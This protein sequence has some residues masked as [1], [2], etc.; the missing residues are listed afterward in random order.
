[1]FRRGIGGGT[2]LAFVADTLVVPKTREELLLH[3]AHGSNKVERSNRKI[4][5]VDQRDDPPNRFRKLFHQIEIA[6]WGTIYS[7]KDKKQIPDSGSRKK[8]SNILE[9]ISKMR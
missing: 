9:G 3:V 4:T 2:G 5:F 8:R 7:G 6:F 1:M